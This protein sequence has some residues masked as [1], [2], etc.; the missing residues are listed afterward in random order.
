MR[1]SFGYSTEAGA[2]AGG[3]FIRAVEEVGA[4]RE[5]GAAQGVALEAA[6]VA[7]AEVAVLAAAAVAEVVLV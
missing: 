2:V 1:V 3:G 5:V 6:R 4:V 7:A